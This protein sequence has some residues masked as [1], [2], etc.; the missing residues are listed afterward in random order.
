MPIFQ[1]S[2]ITKYFKWFTVARIL[3][4]C[5]SK[6]DYNTFQI[7]NNKGADQSAKMH[8]L[9]C[10]FVVHMQQNLVLSL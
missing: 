8:K 2:K 5:I 1:S 9:A 4:F 7:G 6:F 3:K 10:A